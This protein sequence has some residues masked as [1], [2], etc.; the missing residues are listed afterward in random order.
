MQPP[1]N[2]K[3][4]EENNIENQ[5]KQED[6]TM[7][8]ELVELSTTLSAPKVYEKLKTDDNETSPDE[9]RSEFGIQSSA[10]S[11][12]DYASPSL[13]SRICDRCCSCCCPCSRRKFMSTLITMAVISLGLYLFIEICFIP[14]KIAPILIE[15]LTDEPAVFD[16]TVRVLLVGDSMFG[17]SCRRYK[18]REKIAAFLPQY[19][20]N[21]AISGK[22]AVKATDLR[23]R[24]PRILPITQPDVVFLWEN[25][26]VSNVNEHKLSP[27]QISFVRG[28]FTKNME[29]NVNFILNY[30][31]N[32]TDLSQHNYVKK[33]ALFGPGMLNSTIFSSL[34]GFF[35]ILLAL[36]VMLTLT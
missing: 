21:L 2:D 24:L 16:G 17:I 4:R 30:H 33:M 1:R 19:S 23:E 36:G 15:P 10:D 31:G 14:P 25:S 32:N 18:L 28:N 9:M 26:D 6:N 20:L 29:W 12:P 34:L 11:I 35:V 5:Q 27:Q 8:R 22:S 7:Y 3:N 13:C